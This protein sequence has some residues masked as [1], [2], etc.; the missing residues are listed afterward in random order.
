MKNIK[1]H[2]GEILEN[3][4]RRTGP[5]LTD[6]AKLMNVNR[7]SIYNWFL[8]QRLKPERIL[9]IG[10]TI[11]HDFSLEFP[12]FF[13]SDDFKVEPPPEIAVEVKL[14]VWKEKYIDLL[15]RYNF[16]L[17]MKERGSISPIDYAFNV[18]FVNDNRNEYKLQ[19]NNAPSKIFIERCKKA[20][21]KISGINR[22]GIPRERMSLAKV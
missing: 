10:R 12:E 17:E 2:H 19:L 20:G 9:R 14:D 16:L 4:I 22:L 3:V 21:Y 7:R 6:L 11:G 5:S 8:Q 15:E 18:M 1:V 13:V